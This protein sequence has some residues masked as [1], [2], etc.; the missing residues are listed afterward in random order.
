MAGR[1]VANRDFGARCVGPF[2]VGESLHATFFSGH[3]PL[4]FLPL[5]LR[6]GHRP[7]NGLPRLECERPT[8]TA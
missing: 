7:M 3:E 2:L 1:C 5:D 4:V 6:N 8:L